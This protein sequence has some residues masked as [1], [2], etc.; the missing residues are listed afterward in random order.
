MGGFERCPPTT[1]D[2]PVLPFTFQYGWIWKAANDYGTGIYNLIYI[3]IWVDLKGSDAV[4]FSAPRR[5]LHSNM[6][7]FES[8]PQIIDA[9]AVIRFTFQYGWIWK[10]C[11]R[12]N[13]KHPIAIYIPIWVDLKAPKTL[14]ASLL[15]CNLH[16]NMGGFERKP[17]KHSM[18]P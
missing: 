2:K 7:G 15:L 10:I 8:A 14:S 11:S 3:P 9:R 12:R 13:G 4:R 16:S 5:D 17:K 1:K 18:K 6:G